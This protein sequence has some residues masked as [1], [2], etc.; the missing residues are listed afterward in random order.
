MSN[1]DP[2][3]SPYWMLECYSPTGGDYLD[4][5]AYPALDGIDSWL[6]GSRFAKPPIEP[7]QLE[8]DPRSE[9]PPKALYDAVIPL[10]RLD[11]LE[12]LREA[13]V[14]NLDCY[15]VEVSHPETK[16]I[17]KDY[18][19]VNI[20]GLISAANL[21]QSSFSDPS[22]RGL[23]DMDFNGL[24]IDPAKAMNALMFRLAECVS[25]VVI[26]NSVKEHLESKGGFGL[27]FVPPS[28]WIG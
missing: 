17:T 14:D 26:H 19:A 4:I 15:A 21:R 24:A 10:Y 28:D 12:A 5:L 18:S 13:G 9:G 3:G 20:I 7:I 11:L 8:W 2:S 22:G 23:L 6:R 16:E 25:G 1:P 27:T